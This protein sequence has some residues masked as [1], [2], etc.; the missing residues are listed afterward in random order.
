MRHS[1]PINSQLGAV[2]RTFVLLIFVFA[3]RSATACSCVVGITEEGAKFAFDNATFIGVVSVAALSDVD[4][5]PSDTQ[6]VS[7]T[8]NILEHVKGSLETRIVAKLTPSICMANL[9]VESKYLVYSFFDSE[10]LQIGP[11]DAFLYSGTVHND[12][13]LLRQARRRD[14]SGK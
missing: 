1:L 13:V 2:I 14:A 6:Y 11:C 3:A 5:K 10:P 4:G 7:A 9:K 12:L 8:L